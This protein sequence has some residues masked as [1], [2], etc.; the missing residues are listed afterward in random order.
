VIDPLVQEKM[1]QKFRLICD[2]YYTCTSEIFRGLG[3]L[4][5]DDERFKANYENV[6]PGLAEFFRDA[7]AIYADTLEGKAN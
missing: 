1:A 2:R 4:Y 7:M 3:Q 5:V 6:K